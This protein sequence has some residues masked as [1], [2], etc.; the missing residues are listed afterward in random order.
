MDRKL[1]MTQSLFKSITSGI[2]LFIT[3]VV[4]GASLHLHLIAKERLSWENLQEHQ[5]FKAKI[6]H[7]EGTMWTIADMKMLYSSKELWTNHIDIGVSRRNRVIE[8]IVKTK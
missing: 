2:G 4:V 5:F 3:I 1:S 7:I 6:E 8:D